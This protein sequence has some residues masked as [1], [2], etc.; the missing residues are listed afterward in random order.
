MDTTRI[1]KELAGND[2]WVH[3]IDDYTN[4]L[5]TYIKL[6]SID[7]CIRCSILPYWIHEYLD[8]E[9]KNRSDVLYDTDY[10]TVRKY[11]TSIRIRPLHSFKIKL[12]LDVLTS[13]EIFEILDSYPLVHE[14]E[15]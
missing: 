5:T 14:D 1:F 6:Y 13:E 11:M 10:D 4:G 15:D 3:V 9:Y 7:N 8:D 2:L 12:P